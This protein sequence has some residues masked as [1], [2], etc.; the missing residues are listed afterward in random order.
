MGK[1]EEDKPEKMLAIRKQEEARHKKW[2]GN[3]HVILTIAICAG[4]SK[5]SAISKYLA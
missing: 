1:C 2:K 3:V 4:Q 5:L